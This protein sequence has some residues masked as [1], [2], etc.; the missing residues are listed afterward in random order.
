MDDAGTEGHQ[1]CRLD[2]AAHR[3]ETMSTVLHLFS[4]LGGGA[5]G[6]QRAGFTSVGAFDYDTPC[7]RDLE[8]LTGERATVTDLS[9]MTPDELRSGCTGR[10]DV[11]FTSPPCKAF[12]GCLPLKTSATP[13]YVAMSS[14]ALRGIW[15]ALEAWPTPPPLIVMENVPRIMSR[16]RQWLDQVVGMLHAYGYAVRESTH[17]CGELGGLAQ[18]RRRFLLVARHM[19]QVPEF[20]YEPPRRRVRAIGEVLG[21]LPVPAPGCR[22]GGPMHAL[23]RL[24]ALNWV[25]LALIPAGGDWRDLPSEVRLP[26]RAAR[27]NG[28]WGVNDWMGSA[29]TVVAHH[30]V[31][32]SW[33]SVSDPRVSCSP[34]A[35]V[36]GVHSMDDQCGA[37]IASAGHDSGAF[38]VAD[39]RVQC[40]RREGGHG[41]TPWDQ[42]STTVIGSPCIDNGP[43]QVADPRLEH[44]PRRGSLR[45]WAEASH[46]VIGAP[47]IPEL[48][49]GEP[50][51]LDDRTPIHLVIRAA[52]GTWH[53]PMTTLEL[54][55]LQGFPTSHRDEWL[56][57]D[58]SSHQAW[59]QR[60][61]NAVPPPSAEAI[62]RSCLATLRAAKGGELLMDGGPVWVNHETCKT[63]LPW[64]S[65][66]GDWVP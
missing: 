21:E 4:G 19:R 25:R 42:P 22:D 55:A 51:D 58:G 62:A 52:D 16:G 15:L 54:A 24:S 59:R 38:S 31:R 29:H 49:A 32:N 23:P 18:R 10:P 34:R 57:L 33:A 2:N 45:V 5:L 7:C 63:Q 8:Y 66:G 1:T 41:V 61:G 60:I 30:D 43:W 39:P 35:G 44:E 36:Y 6:F 28:P 11:V 14:L 48:V 27:Q 20:L 50:L 12:S 64:W 17:D 3:G 65:K 40:K 46:V 56:K 37:V 9:V 26:E 13:E 53:R 47:R